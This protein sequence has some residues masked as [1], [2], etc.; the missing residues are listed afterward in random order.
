[1]IDVGPLHGSRELY[2]GEFDG[3]SFDLPQILS[4]LCCNLYFKPP[5]ARIESTKLG[6][7]ACRLARPI[8]TATHDI[9]LP[10]A[11][12]ARSFMT[13]SR[14]ARHAFP[15]LAAALLRTVLAARGTFDWQL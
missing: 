13:H 6:S 3:S 1:M 15:S 8:G 14:S 5:R 10:G 12:L 7:F 2:V 11:E 9:A 4:N